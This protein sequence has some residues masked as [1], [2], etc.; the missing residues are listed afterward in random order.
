MWRQAT[1]NKRALAPTVG[2]GW[3]N[4]D[5]KLQIDWNSKENMMSVRRRVD[6]LFKGCGCRSGCDT[7]QM[8]LQEEWRSRM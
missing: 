6:L 2:N 4:E 3:V 5:G 8:Q 1:D 7:E